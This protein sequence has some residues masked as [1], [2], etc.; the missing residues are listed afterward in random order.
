MNLGD[1]GKQFTICSEELKA[2][3]SLCIRSCCYTC[4]FCVNDFGPIHP[5]WGLPIHYMQ[6][7]LFW[8]LCRGNDGCRM[9]SG[10]LCLG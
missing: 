2:L 1:W 10:K 6:W 7:C 3:H 8:I 9:E 5:M 4:Q